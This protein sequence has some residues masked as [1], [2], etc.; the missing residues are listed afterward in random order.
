MFAIDNLFAWYMWG[1]A[2]QVFVL[3]MIGRFYFNR[4]NIAK[5]KLNVNT[6][7]SG[8]MMQTAGQEEMKL[9]EDSDEEGPERLVRVQDD[10]RLLSDYSFTF[11]SFIVLLAISLLSSCITKYGWM[12]KIN[13]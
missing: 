6:I 10:T 11:A 5:L 13:S 4:Q 7:L 12:S 8:K 3:L 1:V 9:L 2:F